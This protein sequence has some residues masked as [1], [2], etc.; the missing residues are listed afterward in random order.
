MVTRYDYNPD[1]VKACY[2]A[3]IELLTILGEYRD[4]SVIIGGW[5]P[6][7]LC[8]EHREEHTGSLDI[9]LA[10]DF[11]RIAEDRYETILRAIARRGWRPGR[12]PFIFL[13]AFP[14]PD[15][16]EIEVEIN[17]L[18]G[19]YGGRARSRR[20]QDVQNIK[21]RKARGSDLVFA[22][23]VDIIIE[24]TLPGGGGNRVA[25]K[26]ASIIPFLVTKGMA[27]WSRYKEKDAYDIYFCF[28]NYPGGLEAIIAQAQG[29]LGNRL[30]REGLGKIRAKFASVEDVGPVWAANFEVPPEDRRDNPEA[31]ERWEIIRRDAFERVESVMTQLGI[32]PYQQD[33][34]SV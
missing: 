20:H 14:L 3:L 21:A 27:L 28:R 9:D 10:L 17:F 4:H 18:A 16:R 2:S 5:V 13:K 31:Q 33:G 11:S 19:E 30:V 7:F 15:G 6:Y 12:E 34:G 24:G 23:P 22:G 1:E 26:V 25:V 29:H 32:E 8:P